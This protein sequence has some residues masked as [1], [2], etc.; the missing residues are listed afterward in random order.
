[1]ATREDVA[2][3]LAAIKAARATGAKRVRYADREIEYRSLAEMNTAIAALEA[4]LIQIDQGRARK[5]TFLTTTQK[6]L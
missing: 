6:G 4:E 1:M 5:R 3:Q 2:A